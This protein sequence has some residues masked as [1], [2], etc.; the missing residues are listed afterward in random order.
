MRIARLAG[1]LL[2]CAGLSACVADGGHGRWPSDGRFAG[3]GPFVRPYSYSGAAT[4]HLYNQSRG[5]WQRRDGWQGQGRNRHGA[6][7][8]DNRRVF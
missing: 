8:H 5:S 3:S 7:G 6:Y 1:L 4:P 2:A